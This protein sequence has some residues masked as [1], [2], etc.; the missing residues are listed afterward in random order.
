MAKQ[1]RQL[2]E[3]A[4]GK[5]YNFC[6]VL[7][8]CDAELMCLGLAAAFETARCEGQKGERDVCQKAFQMAY[9]VH[10]HLY[11]LKHHEFFFID[12]ETDY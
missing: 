1:L 3:T 8:F 6:D 9:D 10:C 5:H 4:D 2:I 11:S 7:P 12:E